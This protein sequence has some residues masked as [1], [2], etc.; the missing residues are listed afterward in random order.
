TPYT[1]TYDAAGNRTSRTIGTNT[2]TNTYSLT[3]NRLSSITPSSGPI[4]VLNFD[5]NGATLADGNNTYVYDVRGRMESA[6]STLGT[7]TYQVNAFG[8][9]VRKSGGAV[10]VVFTYDSKGHLLAEHTGAGAL[11]RE[12]VWLGDTPLAA[13]DSSGTYFVH[14]DHQSSPRA[15]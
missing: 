10:D 2:E 14:S 9:R 7:M 11:V 6:T 15:I 12:Y 8:Q 13:I 4:R 1:Y 3:S 5:A